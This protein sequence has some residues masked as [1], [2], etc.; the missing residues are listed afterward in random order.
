LVS[1]VHVLD[2]V[3]E[4]GWFTKCGVAASVQLSASEADQNEDVSTHY[5]WVKYPAVKTFNKLVYMEA[6]ARNGR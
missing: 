3:L 1:Q 4:D 5:T 6:E 2:I